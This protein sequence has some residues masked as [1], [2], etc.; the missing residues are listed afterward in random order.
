MIDLI[1][2]MHYAIGL[3]IVGFLIWIIVKV[4]LYFSKDNVPIAGTLLNP[5][6]PAP[7]QPAPAP[8]QIR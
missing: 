2:M 1:D 3:V 4:H 5:P 8:A 6:L 7:G